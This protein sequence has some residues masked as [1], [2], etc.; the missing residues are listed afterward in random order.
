VTQGVTGQ[1]I[2]DGLGD[3]GRSGTHQQ[4]FWDVVEKIFHM[5]WLLELF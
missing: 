4:D 5:F 1:S 3:A 2:I